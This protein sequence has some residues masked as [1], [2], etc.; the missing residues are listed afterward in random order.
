[1]LDYLADSSHLRVLEEEFEDSEENRSI[2]QAKVNLAQQAI[3]Q[4]KQ[5]WE[6]IL[7]HIGDFTVKVLD[8]FR[9]SDFAASDDPDAQLYSGGF[10]NRDDEQRIEQ[11]R[12][13]RADEL[14]GLTLAFDDPRL[15]EMLFRYRARN[16]PDTL[17]L[18]ENRLWQSQRLDRLE[19][20]ANDRQL[21][22]ERFK[23]EIHNAR[24]LHAG[25]KQALNILD[26]LEAWGNEICNTG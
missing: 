15:E 26:Q 18:E 13:A 4:A 23:I 22:P 6:Q 2:L 24:Q 21:N 19:Q 14:A 20:P 5:R 9:E 3:Q 8:V 12:K 25:D 16:Y 1:M 7:Q 17:S 11:V 10:F